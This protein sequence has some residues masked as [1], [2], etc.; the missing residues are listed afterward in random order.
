MIPSSYVLRLSTFQIGSIVSECTL[1]HW[2][3]IFGTDLDLT[4]MCSRAYI[5]I[6]CV[7]VLLMSVLITF[8]YSPIPS[9]LDCSRH[10]SARVHLG[11]DV[12]NLERITTLG[13]VAFRYN[14][15]S[16]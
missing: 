10:G 13:D 11:Q 1:Q 5:N 6:L 2:F 9:M 7:D 16:P 12:S 4:V 3:P 14:M 15:F 8:S